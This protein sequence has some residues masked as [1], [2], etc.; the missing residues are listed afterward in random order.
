[1]WQNITKKFLVILLL[2]NF[3]F[4]P[5]LGM[6]RNH[7]RIQNNFIKYPN[8]DNEEKFPD[9]EF[10]SNDLLIMFKDKIP[11]LGQFQYSSLSEFYNFPVIR[12]KF[13]DK[14]ETTL[15]FEKFLHLIREV[16]PVTRA[17]VN[18]VEPQSDLT[19]SM[20]KIESIIDTTGADK[21]H[22]AG[23]TGAGVKIG[24]IDTGIT[25]HTIEFG[26][27]I[28]DKVVF[29]S[30][31]NG[32]SQDI[33]SVTDTWSGGHG[34]HVAGL[35]A[36]ST[37]G[38]APEAELYSAKIIH[39]RDVLGAG[40]GGGEET[41]LG[42]LEAID[43]LV[44][45]SIDVINIS[46][47]QYH[48]L[49]DG[50]RE[51]VI[52]YVTIHHNVVFCVSAGNSGTV[53][54]DRGSINNP[55]P[56]LQ[57]IAVA[58][59]DISGG[60]FATFSSKGPK[61]DYSLKPDIAAPGISIT[62]PSND[63]SGYVPKS[64]TSMASPIVA[65]AASLLIDFLRTNLINYNPGTIKA[66]LLKGAE[67]T[68]FSVWRQGAG[69]L[70]VSAALN[71]LNTSTLVENFPDISYLHPQKLPF[72]PYEVLYQGSTVEFNLT[73]ISSVIRSVDILFPEDLSTIIFSYDTSVLVGNSTLIPI[74]FYIPH[75]HPLD[76]YN[77]SIRIGNS[78]LSIIFEIRKPI[79]RV[80]FD[81]SFNRIVRHGFTTTVE[82]ILG[83]TSNTI[84]MYSKF[85]RF[86]NY[87]NN[88]SVTPHIGGNLSYNYLKSFDV[89]ILANPFSLETDIYM[90]W[91]E[92]PGG[93]YLS[94]PESTI[95]ALYE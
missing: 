84:G 35:A 93:T 34:T 48:N 7:P 52:N 47:G 71:F 94:I 95:S 77:S 38:L 37:T 15:F 43:Y 74:R 31:D 79:A 65:G 18:F 8:Y 75:N 86:L 82:E 72:D 6:T 29:V 50:L 89:V 88:Y 59:S 2:C 9:I 53:F 30:E 73:V 42:M 33:T 24:I 5:S 22:Q 58:A 16:E 3:V 23:Y 66:A 62:G 70:N 26:S 28:K 81:E 40:N 80:L 20:K 13:S 10:K 83:D 45:N 44:N 64:G 46:L 1:M 4:L 61:P 21:V 91:V 60:S 25:E 90:D 27:R 11:Y 85:V 78:T 14:E 76:F 56:A 49:V 67:D 92:N 39:S 36:G 32:Y 69:F 54:G 63:G 57:C 68:G 55:S 51:D 17:K 12:M 19:Y 41:T 87:D